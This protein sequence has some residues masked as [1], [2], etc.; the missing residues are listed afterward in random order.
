MNISE[1]VNYILKSY[2]KEYKNLEEAKIEIDICGYKYCYDAMSLGQYYSSLPIQ[3][4][5][6]L[7]RDL[8]LKLKLSNDQKKERKERYALMMLS[9]V[10]EHLKQ[11]TINKLARPDFVL[12]KGQIVIGVEVTE[13][14]MESVKIIGKIV[15]ES[16]GKKMPIDVLEKNAIKNHG[17][18]AESYI[19]SNVFGHNY[20]GTNKYDVF[21]Y[22][23]KF[24]KNIITKFKKYEKEAAKYDDMIILCVHYENIITDRKDAIEVLNFIDYFPINKMTVIIIYKNNNN[25]INAYEKV[26]CKI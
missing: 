20:V 6:D 14:C 9:L 23:K 19:Y 26:F 18:K 3:L 16:F 22:K 7:Y 1:A 5:N 2:N 8:K 13:L 12:K 17:K 15:D 25:E 11:F 4:S 24:A 10:K 21:E